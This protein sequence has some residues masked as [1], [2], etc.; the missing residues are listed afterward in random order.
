MKKIISLLSILCLAIT[1]AFAQE[2]VSISRF[3][4]EKITAIKVIGAF[5][6]TADKG[7]P[8]GYRSASRHD[9]SKN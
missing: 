2:Q 8:R 7:N 1:G 5:E 3:Q 9:W 4:G 6:V